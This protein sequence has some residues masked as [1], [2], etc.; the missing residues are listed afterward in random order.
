MKHPNDKVRS[1]AV[2]ALGRTGDFKLVPLML[3]GIRDN[4]VDVN[5]EAIQAL[6]FIARK[7][8]GFGETLAPFASL[9][10]EDQIKNASPEERLRL[11]TPWREKALKDWS[12]WYFSV[13]PFEERGGL[14]E[15]Q[16]AVPLQ[17]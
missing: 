15:L 12:G 13:R 16:L 7:P 9:G 10:T 1:A 8:K 4:S 3:D 5:I 11:A 14:D 2:W 17:K 6:R